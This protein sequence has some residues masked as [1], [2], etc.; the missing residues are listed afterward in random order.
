MGSRP[1]EQCD[2]LTAWLKNG[3]INLEKEHGLKLKLIN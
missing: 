3:K 1:G 2:C